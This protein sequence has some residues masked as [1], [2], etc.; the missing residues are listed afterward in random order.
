[1]AKGNAGNLLQHFIGLHAARCLNERA[2]AFE[3]LDLFAMA[4]WEPAER[5]E[6]EYVALLDSFAARPNDPI[7]SVFLKAWAERYAGSD[8][9]A[10]SRDR[11]YPN[12]M[13]LLL[14]AK[15]KLESI[16]LC[17]HDEGCWRALRTYL[18]EHAGKIPHQVYG[19]WQRA[20]LGAVSGPALV[21]LDPYQ[22]HVTRTA[23]TKPEGYL[24]VADVRG[25]L[26]STKLDLLGRATD[27]KGAPVIAT[28]FSFGERNPEATDRALRV[29][30]EKYGWRVRT[31]RVQTAATRN[32]KLEAWHQAWWCASHD[33]VAGP[34]DLQGEWDRWSAPAFSSRSEERAARA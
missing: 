31:A 8:V 33:S 27:A 22:V 30:L 21:M 19:S 24:T 25:I 17:E 29:E 34:E 10:R 20:P 16:L 4:P 28:L 3:Y 13:T 2:G 18:D 26:G 15:I 32:R 9:P 12:T 11:E 5:A 14:S 1:M 23:A 6:R 7:A